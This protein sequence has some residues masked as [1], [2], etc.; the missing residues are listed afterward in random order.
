MKHLDVVVG[1]LEGAPDEAD[2]ETSG[3]LSY[4]GEVHALG[5]GISAGFIAVGFGMLSLL[6]VVYGAA[7][8]G[9]V[10]WSDGKRRSILK[11]VKA[12]PHYALAG[13][14]TGGLAALVVQ[15]TW[16]GSRVLAGLLGLV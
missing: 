12:E 11:D 6:G 14:V 9:R 5:M 2:T 8:E 15:W 10:A 1:W 16:S 4:T 7:V 3:F 13:V